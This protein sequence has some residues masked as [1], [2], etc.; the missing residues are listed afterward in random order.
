MLVEAAWVATKAPG[1]LRAFFEHVRA[2]RGMQIAVVATARKLACLCW[3]MITR[4]EDYHFERSSLTA[5]K[6]RTL[7]LRPVCVQCQHRRGADPTVE[8]DHPAGEDRQA[9]G[10]RTPRADRAR[11]HA[12]L[13]PE[14]NPAECLNQDVK[15]NALGRRRPTT[16]PSSSA[17]SAPTS[18]PQTPTP[19]RRPLL[20][21]A[22]RHLRRRLKPIHRRTVA[23]IYYSV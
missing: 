18:K 21:R 5:Q 13:Q 16:S 14:L 10:R 23:D 7:Q 22:T 20:P 12:W 15:S 2:R 11:V 17:R 1:P 9:V 3:H 6:L 19:N 4:E 8:I